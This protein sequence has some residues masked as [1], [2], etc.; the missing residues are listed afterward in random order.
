MRA[1]IWLLGSAP[2]ANV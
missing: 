2:F 1:K